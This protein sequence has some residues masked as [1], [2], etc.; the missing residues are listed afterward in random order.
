VITISQY[1]MGRDTTHAGELTKEIRRNAVETV[2]RTNDVLLR[3]AE[4]TERDVIDV[5]SGWRP[6]KLNA[7]AGGAERSHH[8]SG[9]AIDLPDNDGGLKKWLMANPHV[10]AECGLYME[11][12]DATPTWCHLQTVA[13]KSG[14]RIFRP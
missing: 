4:A 14:N 2:W 8:L 7:L 5:N 6:P 10:L 9:R 3:Y 12:P 13:P 1:W 11:H